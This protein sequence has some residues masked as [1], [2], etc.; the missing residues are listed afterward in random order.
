MEE[1]LQ[2]AKVRQALPT[3]KSIIT[4]FLVEKRKINIK[5]KV[6]CSRYINP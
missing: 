6:I 4:N 1:G 5:G 2:I 3:G